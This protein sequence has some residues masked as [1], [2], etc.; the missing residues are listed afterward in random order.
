MRVIGSGGFGWV[1]VSDGAWTL[2]FGLL[3]W[4]DVGIF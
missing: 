2:S 3:G 4:V 1:W